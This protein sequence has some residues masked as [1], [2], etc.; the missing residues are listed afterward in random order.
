MCFFVALLL[1]LLDQSQGVVACD[2][3]DVLVGAEIVQEFE[4]LTRIGERV[5]LQ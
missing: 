4:Q 2:E 5:A 3:G 1:N